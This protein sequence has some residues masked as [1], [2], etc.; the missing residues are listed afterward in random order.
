MP[1]DRFTIEQI[2]GDMLPNATVDQKIATGFHRNTMYNEEGGVD[3][4]ESHFEV[5]V[6][7]VNTTST[8]WLGSTIG[9]AQCHNHKYDPFTQKEYYQ[10][11]AF[12][13]NAEKK[14]I[15][16]GGESSKYEEP[17]LD[18]PT[19]EQEQ[20]RSVLK[21]RIAALENRLDT[22]TPELRQEQREW[23]RRVLGAAADWTTVAFDN[24]KATGGS[25]LERKPDG[26]IVAS[27]DNP[28]I[29]TYMLEGNVSLSK[30]TGLRIEALPDPTLPRGGPG[31]DVY[32]NFVLKE[33]TLD[34]FDGKHWRAVRFERRLPMTN[35][36]KKKKKNRS[37]CGSSMVRV[38]THESH[39]NSCWFRTF[40]RS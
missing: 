1:F 15:A 37:N 23:E 29:E 38:R 28:R 26:S 14:V 30:I 10:L 33:I 3:K 22:D 39:D 36:A 31:R 19:P 9:C 6:D 24:V 18:L 32:G 12:F 25:V 20:R 2:A 40:R 17:N 34:F 35:L 8:V 7:R 16:N 4:D 27:G 5:L 21:E 11:M 13:S